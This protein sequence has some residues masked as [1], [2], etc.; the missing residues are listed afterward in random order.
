[1]TTDTSVTTL[2]DLRPELARALDQT[3]RLI[4]GTDPAAAGDP[5]PCDE[6][7]VATLI[8]HLQAVVRRIGVVIA[9]EPFDSVPS[10]RTSVDWAGEWARGRAATDAVLAV[11]ANL[12][13]VVRVP[14]GEVP[15]RAA[16][17]SYI[18]ELVTHGWDLAVATGRRDELDPALA[19]VA[20]PATLTKIPE[21][22]GEGIPFGPVVAVPDD[23]PAYDRLIAWSGRNPAWRP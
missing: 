23:A 4:A 13:R 2:P 16:I 14:W 17:A 8:A 1:M 6:F 11:D 15:A 22:R 5:T 19:D 3:G 12:D 10:M 21:Q 9:G 7:D 20:L 18:G